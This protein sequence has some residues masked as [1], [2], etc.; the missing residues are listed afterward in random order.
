MQ[1]TRENCTVSVIV[2]IYNTEKYLGKC[3][4]SI[5]TQ[6]YPY[7]EIICV[8]DG[9]TDSCPQI[10]EE[11]QKKDSRIVVVNQENR[12]LSAARN[13]GTDVAKGQYIVYVDADDFI[14][15]NMIEVL[16][17]NILTHNTDFVIESVWNYD[18]EIQ[19]RV[20]REDSYYT[21][22]WLDSSFNNRPI[23]YKE[24]LD[25]LFIIPVM[26]WAKIYRADFLKNS[27][28]RFPEGLIYE[29]NPF[30]FELLF[31]SKSFSI[32]RR[33]LYNYRVNVKKSITKDAGKNY[34]DM[35]TIMNMIEQIL[36]K[37][38]FYE[39][40]KDDFVFYRLQHTLRSFANV[41]KKYEKEYFYKIQQEFLNIDML[42]YNEAVLARKHYYNLYCSVRNDN[43]WQYK[44]KKLFKKL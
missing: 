21:M 1:V 20:T 16:L 17:K 18:D 34:G 42:Y 30:F 40:I 13:A 25:K 23:S 14:E 28:V 39:K 5:V 22:S 2:P 38:P 7:L 3:L 6:S 10:V 11:Y 32:D 36:K 26:A 43:Y 35:L 33:Q 15:V 27:G 9:S 37:Q 29:D 44:L 31:K 12:G 19:N 4:H 24:V 41:N 8:N